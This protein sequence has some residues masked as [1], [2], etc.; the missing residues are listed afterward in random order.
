MIVGSNAFCFEECGGEYTQ[1]EH[2]ADSKYGLFTC[3]RS[4]YLCRIACKR[5]GKKFNKFK[6]IKKLSL[7][8]RPPKAAV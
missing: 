2:V 6:K 5:G 1:C 8:T 3:I 7:F 4:R